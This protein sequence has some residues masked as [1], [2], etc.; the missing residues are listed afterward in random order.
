M[1]QIPF[2]GIPFNDIPRGK[3]FEIPLDEWYFEWFSMAKYT[4][5]NTVG[6]ITSK[7]H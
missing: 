4:V 1:I 3:P 6:L 7:Y 5:Q 2:N